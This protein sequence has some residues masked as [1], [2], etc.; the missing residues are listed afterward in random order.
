MWNGPFSGMM[1]GWAWPF[2]G[3]IPLLFVAALIAAVVLLVRYAIGTG[4]GGNQP[5][6]ERRSLGLDTLEER[7]ARGEINRDEYLQ[8]RKDILG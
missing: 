4:A 8:K 1:G 6:M 2:M 5:P 3:I 7:Y